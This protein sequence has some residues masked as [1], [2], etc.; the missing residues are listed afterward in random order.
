M[1]RS[2]G[3]ARSLSYQHVPIRYISSPYT[4]LHLTLVSE[5]ASLTISYSR[6]VLNGAMMAG[7]G[8]MLELRA[9]RRAEATILD[10]ILGT[11]LS[12]FVK[13]VA[14]E[15]L[16]AGLLAKR[17]AEEEVGLHTPNCNP[18]GRVSI[19]GGGIR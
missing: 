9:S 16:Q 3:S 2:D 15:T 11:Y 12:E 13:N 18:Y 7:G 5:N 4:A 10:D 8:Q 6:A 1:C 14:R 19:R 17:R